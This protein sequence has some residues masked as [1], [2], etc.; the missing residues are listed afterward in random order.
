MRCKNQL[1]LLLPASVVSTRLRLR[2]LP[3]VW[4]VGFYF[5]PNEKKSMLEGKSKED[6]EDVDLNDFIEGEQGVEEYPGLSE[7][8]LDGF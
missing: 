8:P 3:P 5:A 4:Q 7:L 1:A 2:F 6:K